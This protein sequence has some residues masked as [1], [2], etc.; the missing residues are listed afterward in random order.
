[1]S[2]QNHTFL[3]KSIPLIYLFQFFSIK[4]N[5][6][7]KWNARCY[8]KSYHVRF[9][10]F[11]Y[12]TLLLALKI[13]LTSPLWRHKTSF[14]LL[15]LVGKSSYF[16]SYSYS[17]HVGNPIYSITRIVDTKNSSNLAKLPKGE[18]IFWPSI[19]ESSECHISSNFYDINKRFSVFN[20]SWC[21]L[22]KALKKCVN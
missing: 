13:L 6:L 8:Q 5:N 20:S 11:G 14:E 2:P 10:V 16:S 17:S 22:W 1:M 18:P 9:L 7:A 19:S 4:A 21:A 12:K 3:L 15:T